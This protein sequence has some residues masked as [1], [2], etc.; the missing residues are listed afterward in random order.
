MSQAPAKIAVIG[1]GI[2]GSAIASRLLEAG[3]AVTVFDLDRAKVSAL[4]GKGAA[5]AASVAAATQASDFV[6]LSLNHAN[7]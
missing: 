5:S 7:I 4:A 1:A 3:Q 2:M 6:I